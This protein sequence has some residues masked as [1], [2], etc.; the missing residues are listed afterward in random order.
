MPKISTTPLGYL[1]V[2]RLAPDTDRDKLRKA[3]SRFYHREL[4]DGVWMIRTRDAA[5]SIDT[6]VYKHIGPTDRFIVAEITDQATWSE[7]FDD[8]TARWIKDM[9]HFI[10]SPNYK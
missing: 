1:L 8:D 4:F 10:P 7:T 2:C 9:L 5:A 6:C 3:L